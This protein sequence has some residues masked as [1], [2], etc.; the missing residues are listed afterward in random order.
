[1]FLGHLSLLRPL[2][3]FPRRQ[4]LFW[5]PAISSDCYCKRCIRA[6][7]KEV[8]FSFLL[9]DVESLKENYSWTYSERS[10]S[11]TSYPSH[12]NFCS[13]SA[14]YHKGDFLQSLPTISVSSWW[15]HGEM[16]A[17]RHRSYL[18]TLVSPS[19]ASVHSARLHLFINHP[20]WIFTGVWLPP[21]QV[22]KCLCLISPCRSCLFLYS[23]TDSFPRTSVLQ[24]AQEKWIC[25]LSRLLSL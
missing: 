11:G 20:G 15:V 22:S 18:W 12:S 17:R 8:G 3:K 6:T 23:D 1:M 7:L 5:P 25:C 21:A 19:F 4:W 13:S 24:W 14:M 2:E 9:T 16:P 10:P